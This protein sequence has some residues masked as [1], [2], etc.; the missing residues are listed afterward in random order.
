MKFALAVAAKEAGGRREKVDTKTRNN[1]NNTTNTNT[2]N[3]GDHK[4]ERKTGMNSLHDNLLN[5][6]FRCL[7][8][9]GARLA[10]DHCALVPA[11]LAHGVEGLVSYRVDVRWVGR[12][13]STVVDFRD[14]WGVKRKHL[15]W[16]DGYKDVADV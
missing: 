12:G 14:I 9:A 16:V 5:H 2:N 11:R 7:R 3:R 15:E 10:A 13:S 8:L 6:V 1:N 4:N